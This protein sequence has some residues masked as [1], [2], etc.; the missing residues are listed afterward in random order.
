MPGEA[1]CPLCG[2]LGYT[3]LDL[4]VG[5]PQFGKLQI[6]ACRQPQLS[7]KARARLFHHSNLEELSQLTFETFN[8]RGRVGILPHHAGS[9]ESAYHA[10]RN[11]AQTINGW[12][13]IHGGYGCGKTHL[14]A[15][16]ANFAAGHGVPT[17]FLTAPDLL[18]NLRYTFSDPDVTFE[19]RFEDI[20]Q[21]GLLVLDDFGAQ[22]ATPWAQEKLFQIL[23]YRYINRL[24]T[25]ITTNYNIN[26]IDGRLRSRISDP[27][28]VIKIYIQ[29]PDFRRP[30]DDASHH[31]LSSLAYV[32]RHTFENFD[33]RRNEGLPPDVVRGLERVF[34]EARAFAEKPNGWLVIF[35]P[36]GSGK[37]HLAAAI[38]N[39]QAQLG[40]PPLFVMVPDLLDHLRATF[41]P[42]GPA[43]YD[44]RFDE[45]RSAP[46][47]ILDDFG[48]QAMTPWVKE[49]LYQLFNHRYNA[50]LPTVITTASSMEQIDERIRSRLEDPRLVNMQVLQVPSYHIPAVDTQKPRRGAKK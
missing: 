37:T 49:K 34:R 6:C 46:L 17:L 5:H 15:A 43:R 38:G 10:A 25:V 1:G 32:G 24:P 47:L 36:Y 14:A 18:D 26:E 19:E 39:H 48:A 29:A 42:D 40:Y 12:L 21:I 28:L 31:P 13:L 44:K 9:I 7:S 30:S 2:G 33:L 41:A 45:I 20:R 22:S 16:I 27:E 4:P 50:E 23:N 3:R 8:P 35:G 11:F